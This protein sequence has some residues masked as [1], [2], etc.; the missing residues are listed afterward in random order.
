MRGR[1]FTKSEADSILPLVRRVVVQIRAR[2]RLI[3]RKEEHLSRLSRNRLQ[4]G[5]RGDLVRVTKRLR[6]ELEEFQQELSEFG[7]QLR[8]RETGVVEVYSHLN[9][10]IVFLTWKPGEPR[11]MTWHSLESSHASRQPLPGESAPLEAQLPSESS[12]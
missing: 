2:H 4:E 8:D 12:Q 7:C 3:A 6:D 1:I 10:D 5:E 11:F 9:G